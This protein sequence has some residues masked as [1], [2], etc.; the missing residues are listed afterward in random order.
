MPI[1]RTHAFAELRRVGGIGL[2]A[3][4]LAALTLGLLIGNTT[5]AGAVV[6][7]GILVVDSGAKPVQHPGGG[8]V[9]DVLVR[10]GDRVT[11]GQPV[12]QLDQSATATRLASATTQLLQN[13]V[14]LARLVAERDEQAEPQFTAIER[15]PSIGVAE[16]EDVLRTERNQFA[17]RSD[18]LNGQLSQ[19]DE[20]LAQ[21]EAQAQA[22]EAQL[23]SVLEQR[24]LL[25]RQLADLR[26]LYEQ[27]LLPYSRLSETELALV[28]AKGSEGSLK[29]S[30]TADKGRV[31]ELKVTRI[32]VLRSWRAQVAAEIAQL[33]ASSTQLI[34]QA[35]L[36]RDQLQRATIRA[37]QDGIVHELA[38]LAAGTV[39]QPA[40]KLMLI[41]PDHDKLVGEVKIRPGDIDQLY[42]GQSVTMQFSAFERATTP[43]V[44]GRLAAISADLVEDPRNGSMYY[45]ARVEPD[46]LDA[47]AARG[48][49]LVPGMPVEAFIKTE[50]RTIFSFLTKPLFDQANRAFR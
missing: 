36:A 45:T 24:E 38:A 47:L 33:Q 9:A 37:S 11:A 15:D 14:R 19:L 1:R 49:S 28:Q 12:V 31:A 6:S 32:Q 34:E 43:S 16:F 4:G 46:S 23:G 10:N 13:Q 50:D 40:E 35:A 25:E 7:A 27:K 44:A 30:I 18:E 20:Q 3:T 41:V 21:A 5:I 17:R 29:S 8:V 22:N 42:P 26:P 48:L 39:I 2:V